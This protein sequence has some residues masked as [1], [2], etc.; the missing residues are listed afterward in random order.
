MQQP[1]CHQQILYRLLAKLG[2][3]K[4]LNIQAT[5]TISN[6]QLK[7]WSQIDDEKIILDLVLHLNDKKLGLIKS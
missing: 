6:I 2:L 1:K 7:S 4:Y 3:T 5:G